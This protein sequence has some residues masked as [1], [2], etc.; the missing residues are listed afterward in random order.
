MKMST[1][2]AA[3]LAT[4]VASGSLAYA[5]DTAKVP[6]TKEVTAQKDFTKL[7][8]DGIAAFRDIHLARIA[9]FDADPATAKKLVAEAQSALKKAKADDSIFLKA[10]AAMKPPAS[11]PAAAKSKTADASAQTAWIPIDGQFTLEEDFVATPEKQQ[12]VARAN[13][14][15]KKGERSKAVETLRLAGI[16]VSTT[17]AALP[18]NQTITGVDDAAKLLDE[19]KFYEVNAKLKTVE[20]GLVFDTVA[21]FDTPAQ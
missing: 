1:L 8:R 4:T 5:A 7:S 6:V 18:L 11:A 3:I 14:H 16:D 20:D 19:N 21:A 10:E 13:E 12:A 17:I 9:V 15:L 2:F